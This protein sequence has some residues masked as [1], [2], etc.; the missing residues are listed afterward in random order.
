MID[1]KEIEFHARI[2]AFYSQKSPIDSII[3]D[4]VLEHFNRKS[5]SGEYEDITSDEFFNIVEQAHKQYVED[6]EKV[7]L[8]AYVEG[9]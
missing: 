6:V 5:L 4:L 1:E 7:T 3:I 8:K 2:P 9:E